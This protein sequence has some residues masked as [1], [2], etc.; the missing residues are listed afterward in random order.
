VVLTGGGFDGTQGARAIKKCGGLIIVQ[1]L[2]EADMPSMPL[3]ALRDGHPD[4]ILHLDEM[5]SLLLDLNK[6]RQ[7]LDQG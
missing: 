5:P 1:Q 2:S 7:A 4:Y 6:G 3:S